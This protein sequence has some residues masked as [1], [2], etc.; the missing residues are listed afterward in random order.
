MNILNDDVL[1]TIIL[2]YLYD[3]EYDTDK[4]YDKNGKLCVKPFII[5]ELYFLKFVSKRFYHLL[6]TMNRNNGLG[7]NSH[8]IEKYFVQI[9]KMNKPHL[10]KKLKNYAIPINAFMKIMFYACKNDY[11]DI[12]RYFHENK[13]KGVEGNVFVYFYFS[14]KV[15]KTLFRISNAFYSQN[16]I[17]FLSDIYCIQSK[18][19]KM[20]DLLIDVSECE[21]LLDHA[22]LSVEDYN[23]LMIIG[24][25]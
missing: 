25:I 2:D 10:F 16:V 7:K 4:Y 5:V 22:L 21:A 12:V 1:I 8:V 9:T 18:K 19:D 17:K 13:V 11:V 3:S 23:H 6:K 15:K 20:Y 24:D 14:A